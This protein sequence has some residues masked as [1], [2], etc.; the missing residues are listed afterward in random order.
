MNKASS[1]IGVSLYSLATR[2]N[3]F[4]APLRS[5]R[6]NRASARSYFRWPSGGVVYRGGVSLL[7]L[8]DSRNRCSGPRTSSVFAIWR[9]FSSSRCR[10]P[11]KSGTDLQPAVPPQQAHASATA[12]NASRSGPGRPH[13]DRLFIVI[14]DSLRNAETASTGGEGI[15]FDV[16]VNQADRRVVVRR[17]LPIQNCKY[18]SILGRRPRTCDTAA[19]AT[20]LISRICGAETT[21]L[22]ERGSDSPDKCFNRETVPAWIRCLF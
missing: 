4:S 20:C 15:P 12:A 18:L 16:L 6:L 7:N 3:S 1:R 14:H 13:V 2:L 9:T 5:P 22:S 19:V 11:N 17:G 21:S 8:P 10:C